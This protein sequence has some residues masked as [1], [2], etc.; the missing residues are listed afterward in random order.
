MSPDGSTIIF[1]ETGEAVGANYSI[2]MRKTDG[3]P[4]IRLGDGGFGFLSPDG[5]WVLSEDRSPARLV[6]LPTGV[7]EPRDLTDN[8]T[9]H[10]NAGWLPDGKSVF[11]STAEPG[12]GPR[13]YVLDIQGGTPR[14]I[15]PEGVSGGIVTPDGKSLLAMDPKRQRWLY[16]IA[17]GEP[18]KFSV[19]LDSDERVMGFSADGQN[20]LVR[21]RAI[22]VK[23]TRV[24]LETGKRELW[25]EI[26]PA[27][28]AGI[29]SIASIRVSADGKAYAYSAG[30]V[31]SD[32]YV[33]DG[34]K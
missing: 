3:S 4:A 29:Q 19:T 28:P 6:L 17:G 30:R 31:L 1:S 20:L 27:D 33:V 32:L 8:K 15:T 25:R 18:Q 5:K 14:A 22:P 10:F 24:N 13:T 34:L 7:G 2:F 9:D 16:P 23:L 11:Y 12:H 26:T 21:T